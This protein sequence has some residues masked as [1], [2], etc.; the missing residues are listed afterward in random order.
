MSLANL[1]SKRD[2]ELLQKEYPEFKGL[3]YVVSC[4]TC[5]VVFFEDSLFNVQ[6]EIRAGKTWTIEKAKPWYFE[7]A[8][9]W[10]ANQHHIILVELVYPS[11]ARNILKDL[12]K[13]WL[14][15]AIQQRPRFK[16]DEAFK[17]AML[18]EIEFMEKKA[19]SSQKVHGNRV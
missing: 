14:I 3:T 5:G 17:K 4:K 9:H 2:L 15:G 11:K 18:K 12:H 13:E 16:S 7:A 8:K 6:A 1:I 19:L 10:I